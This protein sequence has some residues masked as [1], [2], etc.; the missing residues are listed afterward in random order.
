MKDYRRSVNAGDI[1]RVLNKIWALDK[2]VVFTAINNCSKNAKRL[3][4]ENPGLKLFCNLKAL[5]DDAEPGNEG[6]ILKDSC[7][8][9]FDT[10]EL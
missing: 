3:A 4:E 5:L 1:N 10:L 8:C 9:S 6:K 7:K 2:K